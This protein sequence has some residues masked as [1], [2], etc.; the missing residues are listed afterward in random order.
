MAASGTWS[1][2]VLTRVVNVH[3]GSGVYVIIAATSNDFAVSNLEGVNVLETKSQLIGG[4]GDEPISGTLI[5]SQIE[6][7]ENFI[8]LN[9]S[10]SSPFGPEN[11]W[12]YVCPK[13][14]DV[15]SHWFDYVT[16]GFTG[17]F[18]DENGLP[19]GPFLWIAKTISGSPTVMNFKIGY[20][21]T[22]PDDPPVTNR[23]VQA[24]PTSGDS[25]WPYGNENTS[26]VNT[27][28]NVVAYR[29]DKAGIGTIYSGDI[30]VWNADD[31]SDF[32]PFK[33]IKFGKDPAIITSD[34]P[35]ARL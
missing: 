3:W 21:Q 25:I 19:S 29:R 12:V 35:Y 30:P 7:G 22:A 33:G 34:A 14:D 32:P 11:I 5:E 2:D 9:P 16:S 4:V 24:Y 6:A 10:A 13:Q 28:W 8:T 20:E 31:V 17:E 1:P 18:T 15:R 23:M 26:Y 27:G